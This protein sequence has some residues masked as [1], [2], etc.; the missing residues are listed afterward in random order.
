M[1]PLPPDHLPAALPAGAKVLHIG[2]PKTGTTALQWALWNAR[3]DLEAIGAHNVSRQRHERRTALTAAGAMP[4]YWPTEDARWEQ[5][6]EDFR[7]STARVTFWSSESLSTA[8]PD[9]VRYLAERLG[10]DIHI[11][12]TLRALAPLLSS[13]WQQGLRRGEASDLDSWVRQRF[14]EVTPDGEVRHPAPGPGVVLHRF[15]PARILEEWGGVFGEQNLTFVVGDPGDHSYVLRVFES[16]LG[17][18]ADLLQ[19][20]AAGNR[21]LP[22]PEAELLRR[23]A[24]QYLAHD[25]DQNTW[26]ATAGDLRRVGLQAIADDAAP[27]PIVVPRWAAERSNDYVAVWVRA[28]EESRAQVA[29]DPAHLLVD[30]SRYP[31]SVLP[32]GTVDIDSAARMLDE[33]FRIALT[34]RPRAALADPDAPAARDALDGVGTRHLAR[35]LARRMRRRVT[36]RD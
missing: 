19:V 11:I 2:L 31:E 22:F 13:R 36:R 33:F 20:P 1:S 23:F 34:H 7:T 28:L 32:P 18:T 26:M 14:A 30:P 12:V 29:G 15:N 9:R 3:D 35:E 5:L 24:G 10:P 21:S 16:L 25:G 27:Y 17:V 4:P 8:T 6:A